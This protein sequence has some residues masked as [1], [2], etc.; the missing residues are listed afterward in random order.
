MSEYLTKYLN[1]QLI[2]EYE[3]VFNYLYYSAKVQNDE[4]RRLMIDFSRDELEHAR[5]LIRHIVNLGGEP[6]FVLPNI[7]QEKDVIRI[8]IR[9]IAAEES[10]VK[11][12]TMIQQII[13]DPKHKEIIGETIKVEEE[14]QKRLE[15]MLSKLKELRKEK[16]KPS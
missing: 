14:H 3:A 4:L 13:E 2:S 12:Y 15:K 5:M 10:A 9:S 11:K 6:A 16:N 7:G 1:E 8:L